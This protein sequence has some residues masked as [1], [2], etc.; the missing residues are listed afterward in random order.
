MLP[1]SL[2]FAWVLWRQHRIGF[3][4]IAAY[5]LLGT[6]LTVVFAPHSS[7]EVVRGFVGFL[8]AVSTA[9]VP[10]FLLAVFAHGF[11]GAD[12][13]ARESCFPRRLF[14]LPVPT[15]SLV[16]WP[17]LAGAVAMILLWLFSAGLILRPW[18]QILGDNL[19]L[20]WPAFFMAVC[21]AWLQ[22]LSWMPFGLP[23]LRIVWVAAA[24]PALSIL[25]AFS[26]QSGV[27]E[28]WLVALHAS[29][30]GVGWA[31]AYVG[32][33]RARQGRT[34]DW[35][36]LVEPV[37][38]LLRALP[39]S[40][41]PFKS[42]A[43]AQ[44]WLEWRRGGPM[45]ALAT[46]LLLI[47]ALMPL[48]LGKNDVIPTMQTLLTALAA[49]VV[50]AGFSTAWP[51]GANPSPWVKDR[52]GLMPFLAARPMSCAAMVAAM[53]R[54]A[55]WSTLLAWVVVMAM[56]PL[57]LVWTGRFE[58]VAEYWTRLTREHSPA[59]VATGISAVAV[60]LVVWTWKRK[61][62]SFYISL[63]GRPWIPAAIIWGSVAFYL[64][65][66]LTI[67]RIAELPETHDGVLA[68][69][70][71]LLVTLLVARL[72]LCA[73]ACWQIVQ[74]QLVQVGTVVCWLIAWLVVAATLFAAVA[75]ATP[76]E[77]IAVEYLAFAVLFAMPMA[78]LAAAPLALAWN[79]H[80]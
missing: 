46:G 69:L 22:A 6:A 13:L 61:V 73:W 1:M 23:W 70:P 51:A 12:V 32:V 33:A 30:A 16:L 57:A 52:P 11:D 59:T 38:A 48:L 65:L 4:A 53:L 72:L 75:W 44:V 25:A 74:Q 41:A 14:R 66:F 56:V 21:L 26:A 9:F 76:S 43:A 62:D 39:R 58:E 79:R 7:P 27:E 28:G 60:W 15:G 2:A 37:R 71:W 42:P 54:N 36:A 19:P 50:L 68:V 45:L 17:M 40:R 10:I 18:M 47:V 29:L 34:A 20:W 8:M 5:L 80:R 63:T 3:L 49:P 35:R 67:R 64:G 55:V 77:W 31:V 24:I 78:R